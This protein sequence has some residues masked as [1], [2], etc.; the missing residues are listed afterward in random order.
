MEYES[1]VGGL[2]YRY[3][4]G[5][6]KVETVIYGIPNGAGSV[7]QQYEYPNSTENI[8]KLYYHQD[9]LG[10][11]DF[12]TDNIVGK[13]TSYVTYDDWGSP[14]M[15]AVLRV[16]VRELDL[17]T[18]YTVHPYDQLLGVY[19]AQARMYDAGDRRF[20]AAD[21]V[22]GDVLNPLTI[23]Q[24][25]YALNNPT[26]YFD[27]TGLFWD[28]V[29]N[30][31]SE[32]WNDITSWT[33]EKI[34]EAKVWI[35]EQFNK[36]IETLTSSLKSAT[37]HFTDPVRAFDVLCGIAASTAKALLDSSAVPVS[38]VM[39]FVNSLAKTHYDTRYYNS[40]IKGSDALVSLL[41]SKMTY[42]DSFYLGK[43]LGDVGLM[44]VGIGV[45]LSGI[46]KVVEG[47]CI[48]IGGS[49]GGAALTA[50][51]VG[52]PVAYF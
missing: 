52:A 43:T 11:T 20:L 18:E 30:W 25:I 41:A 36:A 12:L 7:M 48:G 19:F 2:T 34:D 35:E 39:D 46:I 40:Y 29:G 28:E 42:Q 9:R 8:V 24:Y 32:K 17:V 50:T 33:S 47:I 45:G 26:K 27:P 6:E 15:K 10:S 13:V 31:F 49:S 4:Y 5:L 1:G 51:G 14:T 16:G 37:M 44:G 38:M 3:V 22:K 21:W 23:V